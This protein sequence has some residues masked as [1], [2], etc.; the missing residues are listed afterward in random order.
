MLLI[1]DVHVTY[2]GGVQALG[3]VSLS[4]AVGE[5]LA[6]V[7]ESGCGKT[8]LALALL[9]LLPPGTT[10]TG[11]LHIGDV[12][13][14][15]AGHGKLSMLRGR[16]SG[17]VVQDP[18]GS[19]NPLV[20]VGSHVIEAYHL[21]NRHPPDGGYWAWAVRQLAALHIPQAWK[22]AT[23]YPH[24]WSG[25]MLQRAAIAA[26]T[27]NRPPLIIAD[28]PTAALDVALA[29]EIMT[30]LRARQRA[31]NATMLL[32]THQLG[33]ARRI[34]DR[35]AVMYAGR[36]VEE[37]TARAVIEDPRHPYTQALV[38]AAT[39]QDAALPEP[40]AGEAPGLA[41]PPPGCAFHP[42]C[43]LALSACRSGPPPP[44]HAGCA[45]PVVQRTSDAS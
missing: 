9:G 37:G 26:A 14:H 5:T 35:I 11:E 13:L 19:F 16:L 27:A 29:A 43:S 10:L 17:L 34:A 18:M 7:G 2:P 32:I 33:L 40:L 4:L 20:R 39:R 44:L 30:Q 22:R 6:L 25:G 3:G 31:D 15:L 45:C 41:P 36:V 28:E 24:Q 1:R 42:R 38:G 8:T 23:H 12:D 21:H